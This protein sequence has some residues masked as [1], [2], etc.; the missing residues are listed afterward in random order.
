[1]DRRDYSPP[2]GIEDDDTTVML[3]PEERRLFYQRRSALLSGLITPGQSEVSPALAQVIEHREQTQ[4]RQTRALGALIQEEL[5]R[6][7]AQ[8]PQPPEPTV[9]PGTWATIP[10]PVA[11]PEMTRLPP[12][13][14]ARPSLW[15]TLLAKLRPR[16]VPVL[17]QMSM[18]ECGAACLAMILSYHGRRTS[19]SEVRERCQ[20]GRDGLSALD[21]VKAARA[22]GLRVRAVSLQQNDLRL[23]SLP[24]IIHWEFNHFIVI[25]R[26]SPQQVEVVDPALGRRRMSTEEFFNGFTGIVIMLEP[27]VHFD[28][29]SRGR[30]T[31]L[32][33]YALNYLKIAPLSLLQILGASLLLQLFG[34][35]VPLLTAV[36][37]DQI[38]PFKL[39]DVLTVLG[40]GLF[41]LIA[42]QTVVTLL[43]AS[44]L[45][46]LQTRVDTRMML[47]FFEQLLSLPLRFLHQRSSGDILAR[48]SSNLIIRDTIS[49]QL[50]STIL[51]GSFVIT[52]L[53]IL[54]SRSAPFAWLT[55][56][57]GLLQVVILIVSS[58]VVQP[59][60]KQELLTQGKFHGYAAEALV[61][62][63]TLEA[64]GAGQRALERWTN[65]FFARMNASVRRSYFSALVETMVTNLRTPA[66]LLLLIIGTTQVLSGALD[67]GTML[68]LVALVT[69]FLTPLGSLVASGQELQLVRSHLERVAD[70]MEAEPEQQIQAVSQPPR[71]TGHIRLEQVQFQ[72]APQSP[73]VL[74]DIHLMIQPHQKVAIVGRTGSG[75]STLGMLLLGF[76]LPTAGEIY[77]DG[78]SLRTLDYQA[79]RA[80]FGVVTQGAT[81]FSGSIRENIALNH[82]G[83]PM[84]QI[85]QAASAAAIHEDILQMPME[86]ETA[87]AEGGSALSG[88]QRQR[89][90]LARALATNPVI[91][92]LDEATSALDVVTEQAI[93]HN[94]R[95]LH[96]TQIIIAHRLSTIRH[97]DL[98]LVLDQGTIVERGTHEDLLSRQGSYAHLIQS[99][100]ASGEVKR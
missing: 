97:A 80:Q 6:E 85:V 77:Y 68:A 44:L 39:K 25:E 67:A 11:A 89:L 45:L 41:M 72:Y 4:A 40:V 12:A 75:K 96:C 99:Q 88:G 55:L 9:L 22:Y 90:G 35:A 82:P 3:S 13:Q 93:E 57:I 91:L 84:E 49:N 81:L 23:V 16:R 78:F 52:Y 58:R 24:A 1:M 98:I 70:V 31:N 34:L 54:F 26:A 29:T 76:S 18:V 60:A 95:A 8:L 37:I 73:V 21:I 79:V 10:V 32:R 100:L 53:I 74:H 19:V 59:L 50:I 64:A 28:Q 38:L 47:S 65:L 61:G 17:L 69:A 30:K 14:P 5:A 48:L 46:Y 62:V 27:G 33:S 87:V 51:D 63:T 43:R 66:P 92:L 86:Y 71:L 83:M 20:V 42:A 2:L 36:V 94:L 7:Q 56:G 15:R